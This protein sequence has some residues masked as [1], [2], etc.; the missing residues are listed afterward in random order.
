MREEDV[1]GVDVAMDDAERRLGLVDELVSSV[2]ALGDARA[3]P[4]RKGDRHLVPLHDEHI[5]DVRIGASGQ[6]LHRDEAV[7]PGDSVLEGTD[8]VR[9][10]EPREDLRL[11]DEH[12]LEL[13]VVG[14]L[15]ADHLQ[16]DAFFAAVP[17][18]GAP[19]VDARHPAA[20]DLG[21]HLVLAE[22]LRRRHECRHGPHGASKPTSKD[23]GWWNPPP[24]LE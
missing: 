21:P 7:V 13:L 4:C 16:R 15:V 8:D 2:Q 18:R 22:L 10:R 11:V 17:E 5:P 24:F 12:A 9:V 1:A 6:E 20:A 3:E 23:R 14:E 19:D